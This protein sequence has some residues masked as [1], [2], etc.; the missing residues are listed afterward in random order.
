MARREG[1]AVLSVAARVAR[2]TDSEGVYDPARAERASRP[3]TA[4][5]LEGHML[6][7]QTSD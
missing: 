6:I 2:R 5:N 4:G 1:P 7:L 3:C